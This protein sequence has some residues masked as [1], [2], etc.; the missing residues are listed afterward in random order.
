MK[1]LAITKHKN[2]TSAGCSGALRPAVSVLAVALVLNIAT[3]P[4]FAILL[5]RDVK[6]F[7]KVGLCST[8]TSKLRQRSRVSLYGQVCARGKRLAISLLSNNP[9]NLRFF[10]AQ[11]VIWVQKLW[12]IVPAGHDVT[13]W[14]SRP[15]S[16][17]R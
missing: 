9:G 11:K 1:R 7:I 5:Q 3:G 12:N 13:Y 8:S 15:R 17:S 4:V 6:S 10:H 16:G 14:Y 2:Q